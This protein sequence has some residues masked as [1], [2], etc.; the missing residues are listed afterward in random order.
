[1]LTCSALSACSQQPNQFNAAEVQDRTTA[2]AN[3]GEIS[4]APVAAAPT[5]TAE[6]RTS[7]GDGS[8][9]ILVGMTGTDLER[10]KLSGELACSFAS[11][12]GAMLLVGRGNVGSKERSQ[13]V[14]KILDYVERVSAPGGYD[15]M[16]RGANFAGQGKTILIALTGAAPTTGG[17]SPPLAATLTYQRADGASR[18]FSGTWTC[19]P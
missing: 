6:A 5:E 11:P 15:A 14:V 13:G 17:E 3:V 7:G 16:L 12:N 2:I 4:P 18:S 8:E 19:G 10:E 1:M 9:I